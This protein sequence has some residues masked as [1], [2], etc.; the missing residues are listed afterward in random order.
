[1]LVGGGG[2]GGGGGCYVYLTMMKGRRKGERDR[3]GQW[4]SKRDFFSH[5]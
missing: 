2:G 1:M 4:G 3:I 5:C